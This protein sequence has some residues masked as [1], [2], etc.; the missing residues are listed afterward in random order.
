[1]AKS[2]PLSLRRKSFGGQTGVGIWWRKRSA[3]MTSIPLDDEG[4]SGEAQRHQGK[5]TKESASGKDDPIESG[6]HISTP[7][8]GRIDDSPVLGWDDDLCRPIYRRRSH[9][10]ADYKVFDDDNNELVRALSSSSSGGFEKEEDTDSTDSN[11]DSVEDTKDGDIL[12]NSF[13]RPGSMGVVT[14][15]PSVINEEES[16]MPACRDAVDSELDDNRALFRIPVL[17][18]KRTQT[19]GNQGKR[20]RP[21]SL[22][23]THE[24]EIPAGF[25]GETR[26]VSLESSAEA[27]LTEQG[28]S[29][30]DGSPGDRKHPDPPPRPN[31]LRRSNRYKPT[32]SAM[33]PTNEKK[34]VGNDSQG[35]RTQ[36]DPPPR[37]RKLRRS[38]R[39]KLSN[40]ATSPTEEENDFGSTRALQKR[41]NNL[42]RNPQ[43]LSLPPPRKTRRSIQ[44]D[45]RIDHDHSLEKARA[46][47]ETLDK[48]QELTLDA[49]L[50]PHV[51]GRVT[52]TRRRTNLS[53]PGINRAYEAYAQ[54]IVGDGTYGIE[55]LCIRDY[56][57]SR[58]L[59][60]QKNGQIADGF[61]DD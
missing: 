48:T 56:A 24:E 31:K 14:A 18:R 43:P 49:T 13:L 23:L 51:S 33:S 2:K 8:V 21:L 28:K 7:L 20:R 40:F 11:T 22:I 55:P 25:V 52:R 44:S 39:N 36:P 46:Y 17:S 58:Q 34:A 6:N 41:E 50:S 38:N 37:P 30:G 42:K 61:L 9:R 29:T 59:Q 54:S 26:R 53:S 15:S 1:M 27:A 32:S 10:N 12:G 16:S 19:F 45:R 4:C 3:P 57:T 35:D 5:S 47:F 60:F